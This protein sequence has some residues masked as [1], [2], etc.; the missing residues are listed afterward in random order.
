MHVINE[1]YTIV[2]KISET[3][4]SLNYVVVDALTGE[5]CLLKMLNRSVAHP[6]P[7]E[8]FKK[9][10]VLNASLRHP[11]IR[12][13]LRFETC[14]SIDGNTMSEPDYF[15]CTPY[16]EDPTKKIIDYDTFI[17]QIA[18]VLSFL[19]E[20]GFFHGDIRQE[21]YFLNANKLVLFDI[22]AF[23]P[24]EI[25][26][27]DDLAKIQAIITE[28]IG[29]KFQNQLRD[30]RDVDRESENTD[31][32][33]SI[34]KQA[35]A[36]WMPPLSLLF[37][38]H[39]RTCIF[40]PNEDLGILLY[41]VGD[42]RNA[43]YW[44]QSRI[45]EIEIAGFRTVLLER[46][47]KSE[48]FAL[49]KVL[50]QHAQLYEKSRAVLH[51]FGHE[52]AKIDA[53]LPYTPAAINSNPVAEKD[54]LIRMGLHLLEVMAEIHPIA[55]IIPDI[56]T[57]DEVSVAFVMKMNEFL[58]SK[59]ITVLA[60]S[61][62]PFEISGMRMYEC[63]ALTEKDI[64]VLLRY[65]FYYYPLHHDDI[66][67]IAEI[68]GGEPAN[69]VDGLQ[70]IQNEYAF[71]FEE[72]RIRVPSH[73]L[74][75]FNSE[76]VL[77]TLAEVLP[78]EIHSV[79][80]AMAVFGG[81]LPCECVA[82]I[83]RRFQDYFL[84]TEKAGLLVVINDMYRV[85]SKNALKVFINAVNEDVVEA[86]CVYV[87]TQLSHTPRFLEPL[88]VHYF[89]TKRFDGFAEILKKLTLQREKNPHL[90]DP[91]QY[92]WNCCSACEKE[93]SHFNGDNAFFILEQLIWLGERF[94]GIEPSLL[95]EQLQP[96]AQTDEKRWRYYTVLIQ[97]GTP[98]EQQLES[99]EREIAAIP[100]EVLMVKW[101]LT[102]SFLVRYVAMGLYEK[103]LHLYHTYMEPL[104]PDVNPNMQF[105]AIT[106]VQNAYYRMANDE[107]TWHFLEKMRVL[108]EEFPELIHEGQLFSL[109]NNYMIF[110]ARVG[111]ND[112]AIEYAF[113]AFAI[114]KRTQDYRSMALINSNISVLL[115]MSN[116]LKKAMGYILQSIEYALK[117]KV[118]DIYLLAGGNATINFQT[119]FNYKRALELHADMMKAF[120]RCPNIAFKSN[121]LKNGM[122]LYFE[123]GL[124]E[125]GYDMLLRERELVLST[126]HSLLEE[127][128][129]YGLDFVY[130]YYA[131]G[132]DAAWLFLEGVFN[133]PSNPVD[134]RSIIMVYMDCIY[135]MLLWRDATS[136]SKMLQFIE[137]HKADLA[138][139][140]NYNFTAMVVLLNIWLGNASYS[141]E[142]CKV[143][144][145][146]DANTM[147]FYFYVYCSNAK[148][149]D[150]L[151]YEHLLHLVRLLRVA[152]LNV[153]EQLQQTFLAYSPIIRFY[154][155]FLEEQGIIIST[156]NEKAFL[157]KHMSKTRNFI[158]KNRAAFYRKVSFSNIA[159][160][161]VMIEKAMKNAMAISG[162]QRGIFFEYDK[163]EGWIKKYEVRASSWFRDDEEYV[164][165]I[166]ISILQERKDKLQLWHRTN[167]YEWPEVEAAVCFPIIDITMARD[168]V[169]K[170]DISSSTS[171]HHLLSLRGAFYFD[172][173][174][175]LVQPIREDLDHL[176]YLREMINVAMYYNKLKETMMLDPLTRLYKRET[177]LD[178]VKIIFGSAN[179]D[180]QHLTIVMSDIDFFK[181]VNDVYGHKR[182]DVVLAQTAGIALKSLRGI[183]LGGRFGGEEFIF[184]LLN[185]S[186]ESAYKVVDRMRQTIAQSAIMSERTISIS[187]GI[188]FYPEDG[189]VLNELIEKADQALL[190]AKETGRNKCV[191]WQQCASQS[192][193]VL[194]HIVPIISNP[195][196]EKEKVD[197]II[198]LLDSISVLN[199]VAHVCEESA[200]ICKRFLAVDEVVFVELEQ[201]SVFVEPPSYEILLVKD[202]ELPEQLSEQCALFAAR[203]GE[204]LS[205]GLYFLTQTEP[206]K[207]LLE[208][209]FFRFIAN[210][211][212]DRLIAARMLTRWN[213]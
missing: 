191:T 81:S 190:V 57:L 188:A 156:F 89:Q 134:N 170:K 128:Q 78:Q 201:G 171:L 47:D 96:L 77:R 53:S 70:R 90:K 139:A 97:R 46:Y 1:R 11:L 105:M 24:K 2:Q 16:Y 118:Y 116:Q 27:K 127:H 206:E 199:G 202:N 111:K 37:P 165:D 55:I 29:K 204:K 183:D 177:W 9:E 209:R 42:Q 212:L 194:A 180:E 88:Q 132:R 172:T 146:E 143:G 108:S 8:Y 157:R 205:F 80:H 43:W 151:Y 45:P 126:T 7:L 144:N 63:S 195:A 101:R 61:D 19:H 73:A 21:N 174:L 5:H 162:F 92:M 35:L 39:V 131:E 189:T 40:T 69:I 74:S 210:I 56:S 94:G 166:I 28:G 182:G 25:G 142:C 115:T 140:D 176:F 175:A 198:E 10:Y 112:D 167:P 14:V 187:A 26:I 104:F 71:S 79:M 66:A 38:E 18:D 129:F 3:N 75:C 147:A 136:I 95:L 54:K 208:K 119:V 125:K 59:R 67:V 154:M 65:V 203:P 85:K 135:Y 186:G 17:P 109:N 141:T 168:T 72:G 31:Y 102:H 106:I 120:D 137:E 153:P 123:L 20:N 181:S 83:D 113:K 193:E 68:S 60:A 32:H 207:P 58:D 163:T 22:S 149:K 152:Y 33:V 64:E 84:Q 86:L 179:D 185:T 91:G 13:P 164:G 161:Q 160:T 196:R 50:L 155:P 100:S 197:L 98:T 150:A 145:I 158:A 93:L 211:I 36:Q 200:N 133:D 51:E 213:V 184:C 12:S 169:V 87:A 82:H 41:H 49:L 48:N 99:I 44:I 110:Y 192:S 4:N 15:F 130:R 121:N 6:F 173:K 117:G 159:D 114:A 30:I 103:A 34:V 122:S 52:F 23:I 138:I 107:K 178:L 124:W 76:N 62:V 148:K